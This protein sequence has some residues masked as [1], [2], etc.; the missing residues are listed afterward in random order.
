MRTRPW[1]HRIFWIDGLA[2]LS[3][4]I[5]VLILRRFLAQLYE[6]P[7]DLLTL[8]GLVN[9]GYAAFGLTLAVRT[10]R[11]IASIVAL[12]AANALWACVCVMLAI[13]FAH[14]ARG[15]GLAH[16]AFEGAF[17]ATLAILEWRNRRVLGLRARPQ[18]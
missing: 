12:S 1:I 4:G 14:E 5:I 13:R 15:L 7:L 16:I 10:R 11:R 6:L 3:A 17:V 9:V 18:A 8:I 2:A